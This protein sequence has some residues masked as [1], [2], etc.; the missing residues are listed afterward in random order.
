MSDASRLVAAMMK[1]AKPKEND[2]VDIV[3]GTVTSINPLKIRTDKIELT[4]SFLILGALCKST[5]IKIPDQTALMHTHIIQGAAT[6]SAYVEEH[7]SHSHAIYQITTEQSKGTI[8]DILL[9]RGLQ[10]GDDV[11][12]IRCGQGQKYYVLQRKEG[13][14]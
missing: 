3:I 7:G 4:E 2:I 9:W 6:D 1:A 14:V 8:P 10:V 11:Y 12:M 5:T 13:I